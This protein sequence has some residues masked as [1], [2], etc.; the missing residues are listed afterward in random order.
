L[1]S[2]A[3]LSIPAKNRLASIGIP[4]SL[5]GGGGTELARSA[6]L[7]KSQ[8]GFSENSSQ[9]T[10]FPHRNRSA[11]LALENWVFPD[12]WPDSA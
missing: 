11:A 12:S 3:V 2:T 9:P 4:Q 6:V 5:H 7:S 8:A 10:I 1:K